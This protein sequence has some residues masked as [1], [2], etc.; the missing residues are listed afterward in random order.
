MPGARLALASSISEPTPPSSASANGVAQANTAWKITNSSANRIGGPSHGCSSTLSRLACSRCTPISLR[1]APSAMCARGEAPLGQRQRAGAAASAGRCRRAS[2]PPPSPR[3]ARR[4]RACAPPRSG[5][6]ARR[7]TCASASGSITSP[8]RSARSTM[9]SATTTGRPSSISSC[10]NTRC[11][12]RLA[13]SSTITS[14]SGCASP[15]N[16][17][18]MTWRVTSSSGLAASSA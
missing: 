5:S 15:G 3:A 10:A 18:R 4:A 13:A 7:A 16:S 2:R 1:I 11:C 17:P 14:T 8:S 6:P 9:L 12:S